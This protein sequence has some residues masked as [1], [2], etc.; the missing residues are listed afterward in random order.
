MIL[1]S[2][3]RILWARKWIGAVSLVSSVVVA[4]GVAKILPPRYEAAGSVML[5]LSEPD[6]VTG[7]TMGG[8]NGRMYQR[9]LVSVLQ[10]DRVALDVVSRL[11]L[12]RRPDYVQAFNQETGGKGELARWIAKSLQDNLN[13]K[14]PDTGNL[15]TV[16]YRSPDPRMAQQVVNTFLDSFI[17]ATLELKVS[18]A[19]QNAKWYDGEIGGLRKNLEEAQ[20]RYADYQKQ[21]GLLG[22]LERFD[23]ESDNLKSLSDKVAQVKAERTS[24]QS[25]LD[26]L[27]VAWPDTSILPPRAQIPLILTSGPVEKLKSDLTNTESEIARA[28]GEVG[29]NHPRL[30]A[31]RATLAAQQHLLRNELLAARTALL[32][33]I[34][35]VEGQ[36]KTTEAAY[37]EQ[38]TKILGMQRAKDE[39]DLLAK[40]VA[41]KQSLVEGASGKASS[42]RLQ[43]QASTVSA[44]VVDEAAVP[45]KPVFPKVPQI[46]AISV[47]AGIAL[48]LA[49]SMLAEMLD[50]RVRSAADLEFAADAKSL[51]VLMSRRSRSRRRRVAESNPI[52]FVSAAAALRSERAA[53]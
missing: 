20:A 43:G 39:L 29:S 42:L 3:G 8:A 37:A 34:E 35:S 45:D 50:R 31:L 17:K 47:A 23:A 7:Q 33:R 2:V 14:L 26:Q 36:L 9:T 32:A 38:Q 46:M 10:S 21:V 6:P 40:D 5:D 52:A 1:A 13:A 41:L 19:Q 48:G 12:T 24:L 30:I 28:V 22:K 25:S 15:M 53:S 16:S 27:K 51:G 49:L 11:N 44:S 4:Y 18:P